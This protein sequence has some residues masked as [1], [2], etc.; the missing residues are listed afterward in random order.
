MSNKTITVFDM[1][2]YEGEWPPSEARACL[3]WLAA[4]IES[5]PAEFRK[6]ATIEFDSASGYEGCHYAQIKIEYTR[7]ETAE[8][9]ATRINERQR[10]LDADKAFHKARLAAL[11]SQSDGGAES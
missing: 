4:K 9:T 3:D 6:S 10:R 5:I 11:E 1:E 2:R 8:E 7:P